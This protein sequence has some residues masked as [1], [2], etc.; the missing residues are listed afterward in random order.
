MSKIKNLKAERIDLLNQAKALNSSE[1]ITDDIRAQVD[2]ITNKIE[3][4]DK[5]IH[6]EAKLMALE[7]MN[8]GSQI[9][10][11][12]N[13]MYDK[14]DMSAV[15]TDLSNGK[16]LDGVAAELS[17]EAQREAAQAG[18]KL[19]GSFHLPQSYM[20]KKFSN[21]QTAGTGSEGGVNVQTD[22]RSIIDYL[23]AS[24]PFI[25][26][27]ATFFTDVT[28]NLSF[29]TVS[30][31]GTDVT[32]TTENG[33]ATDVE[34]TFSSISLTP[35]RVPAY[36]EVSEQLLLQSSNSINDWINRHLGFKIGKA[37]HKKGIT[38]LLADANVNAIAN[39]TDGAAL[40][41]AKVVEFE[42]AIGAANG[43]EELKWLANPSTIGKLKTTEKASG[44]PVYLM[45]DNRQ[46]NGY[47]VVKST[48]MPNNLTKGSGTALSALALG[49][50]SDFYIAMWGGVSFLVNPF[51]KD[52]TGIVRVNAYTY[53]DT[54]IAQA[55]NFSVSKDIVTA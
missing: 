51:A 27:G 47:D 50:W 9:A 10:P 28:G 40:T 39:G 41:W 38:D 11:E 48:L 18:V 3:S 8:A 25:P 19:T 1:S 31:E 4:I 29:P 20:H 6:R 55:K 52:T 36:L 13:R 21:A 30:D 15:I 33:S 2:S 54:A 45:G 46:L 34:A 44:Y 7:S 49:Y 42:T 37:M 24:L 14:L 35:N 17:A 43:M 32:V 12:L 26:L 23:K 16:K 5:D 53:M 22:V